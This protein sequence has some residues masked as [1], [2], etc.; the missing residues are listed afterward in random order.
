MK[1]MRDVR[2]VATMSI[3]SSSE[4]CPRRS[5]ISRRLAQKIR[6]T[7]GQPSPTS[8]RF[9]PV[10][11]AAT[12]SISGVTRPSAGS[13][14][15]PAFQSRIASMVYSGRIAIRASTAIV[16]DADLRDLCCPRQQ[17]CSADD[18]NSENDGGD[19]GVEVRA[20]QTQRDTRHTYEY[21]NTKPCQIWTAW[22]FAGQAMRGRRPTCSKGVPLLGRVAVSVGLYMGKGD[23]TSDSVC[24]SSGR[25]RTSSVATHSIP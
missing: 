19:Y 17:E 24:K 6:I 8:S 11:L 3:I 10:T 4:T 21:Q 20:G 16:R 1:N 7:T 13:K 14:G 25:P 18:S 5:S 15:A 22:G 2:A 23:G 9:E 12:S